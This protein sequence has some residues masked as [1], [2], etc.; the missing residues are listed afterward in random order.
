MFQLKLCEVI[1]FGRFT[2]H[3]TTSVFLTVKIKYNAKRWSKTSN[4]YWL[5]QILHWL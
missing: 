5:S 1:R 2:P 4:M 3:R